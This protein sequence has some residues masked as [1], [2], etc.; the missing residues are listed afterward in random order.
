MLIDNVS[1]PS[2]IRL[3][4]N[5][6]IALHLFLLSEMV[7]Q[8][9][10]NLDEI[11]A[12][13][14][15]LTQQ[16]RAIIKESI[17]AV[18]VKIKSVISHI[19]IRP[20][21]TDAELT[22]MMHRLEHTHTTT[23]QTNAQER[24]FM[25]DM[26][27]LQ[28]KKKYLIEYNAIQL[29]LDE[30]K[31]KRTSLQKD[32][33]EKDATLDELYLGSRKLK[34]AEKI[35]CMASEIVETK[36]TVPADKISLIIGKGGS[37]LQKIEN[38]CMVSIDTKETKAGNIRITGSETSIALAIT[39]VLTIVSTV[40]EE[41]SPSDEKIVCLILDKAALTHDIETRH[42]VRID[43]SRAK[44]V[45]KVIGQPDG[46]R[47]AIAEINLIPALKV[48]IPIDVA[49]L[50]FV[51]GK[52]GAT[53]KLLG[54]GNRVQIDIDREEKHILV[55]G[56]IEEVV[57]AV[58]ALRNII[59][60]NTEVEEVIKV[61][62]VSVKMHRTSFSLFYSINL[63]RLQRG[64]FLL[65]FMNFTDRSIIHYFCNLN[66]IVHPHNL[67]FILLPFFI[68]PLSLY[69]RFLFLFFFL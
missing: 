54:E 58:E 28:E 50:P 65:I 43:I 8:L 62:K 36:F 61:D 7:E 18:D 26:K 23:S 52:G 22:T 17:E 45:C 16:E 47:L 57:T 42:N 38:D 30:L 64:I 46:V 39:A 33:R 37:T 41:F 44:K 56:Y 59:S 69:S 60:D 15:E 4:G 3:L 2:T 68:S 29:T 32:I 40:N 21:E 14:L 67:Y 1:E 9:P 19:G 34:L 11:I 63:Y 35:G 27:K 20:K 49:I 51:V 13:R 5:S 6:S 48:K 10:N 66:H 25:Y 31:L 24:I 53:I 55:L 12:L